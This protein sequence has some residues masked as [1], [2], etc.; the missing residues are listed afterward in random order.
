VTGSGGK[1]GGGGVTGSGGKPGSGGASGG[2]SGGVM[3]GGG[4]G[5]GRSSGGASGA[6]AGGGTTGGG[7]SGGSAGGAS[8]GNG[9]S[10]ASG[11]AG[12]QYKF[13]DDFESGTPGGIP[14]GW[15]A[16]KSY[17]PAEG[18]GLAGD[19]AHS[20]SM[21]VKTSTMATGAER[22]QVSLSTLGATAAN[23][24]GRLF[25]KAQTPAPRG[26]NNAYYH[27]T[28]AALQGT[29]ENRVVDTVED[30]NGKIQY[31]FNVP[32]DS[33][34]TGS[35]YD[36]THDGKWHCAEWHVD[37]SAQSYQFFIDGKEVTQIGFKGNS[38]AKMSSYTALGI[39]AVF[40]VTPTGPWTSWIDD[41][42][43]DD[44]QIGCN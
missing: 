37:V 9:G 2:G 30:P 23:H 19:Q 43:I 34:C 42:A 28:F 18:V 36:W 24:W 39:G 12:K 35:S 7:A 41:V 16:L 1:P 26:A 40:Y 20:G 8:G 14:P 44:S 17:G 4:G 10:S 11:C 29:T 31:I 15:T 5:S 13:C 38:N 25:Y 27:V 3:G 33:C 6:M 32:D 21:S 22:I